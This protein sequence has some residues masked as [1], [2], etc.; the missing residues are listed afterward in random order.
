MLTNILDKIKARLDPVN[1]LSVVYDV[2]QLEKTKAPIAVIN[3]ESETPK[4]DNW[5]HSKRYTAKLSFT[6]QLIHTSLFDLLDLIESV[7]KALKLSQEIER[8]EGV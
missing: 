5:K 4:D 6:I 1:D 3:L 8:N 2:K 7:E